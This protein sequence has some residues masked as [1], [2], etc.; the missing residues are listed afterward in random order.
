MTTKALALCA[1]S[2][3]LTIAATAAAILTPCTP[4]NRRPMGLM[5]LGVFFVANPA[6]LIASARADDRV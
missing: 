3:A 2:A 4:E 5:L 1:A 6:L